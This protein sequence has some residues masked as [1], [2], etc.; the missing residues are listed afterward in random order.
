MRK[1]ANAIVILILLLAMAAIQFSSAIPVR[2]PIAPN[3]IGICLLG[4]PVGYHLSFVKGTPG[5][6]VEYQHNKLYYRQAILDASIAVTLLILSCIGITHGIINSQFKITILKLLAATAGI[7]VAITYF[8]WNHNIFLW[9]CRV[10]L[11][12]PDNALVIGTLKRPFWQNSIAAV[13]IFLASSTVAY[14]IFHRLTRT[15]MQNGG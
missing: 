1:V 4:W 5:G 11:G 14:T 6:G 10:E 15:P 7:S 12:S 9:N 13:F 3:S 8:T 2:A